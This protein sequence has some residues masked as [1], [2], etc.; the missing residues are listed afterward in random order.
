MKKVLA[1]YFA[2]VFAIMLAATTWA[3]L[4]KN[5]FEAFVDLG[6]D[7]WGLATL[8][9]T[10]LGF[11]AFWLWTASVTKGNGK[12]FGWFLFI[13]SMGN[14]AISIFMLLR[15]A[16]WDGKNLRSLYANN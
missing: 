5:V 3:S 11:M 2:L 9:D 4:E 1:F 6:S 10:Y 15:I 7:R 13:M 8:F 12:R 14:F 16:Y